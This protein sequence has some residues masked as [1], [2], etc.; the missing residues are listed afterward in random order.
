MENENSQAMHLVQ[1]NIFHFHFHL[2]I[3]SFSHVDC[4]CRTTW[5]MKKKCFA[6]FNSHRHR[7]SLFVFVATWKWR[8]MWWKTTAKNNLQQWKLV[9]MNKSELLRR[10]IKLIAL[11]SSD[12]GYKLLLL[13]L[14]G[15]KATPR[16]IV[17]S[18]STRAASSS[19]WKRKSSVF[20]IFW[21]FFLTKW[22]SR[23]NRNENKR[24]K[25]IIVRDKINYQV[26]LIEAR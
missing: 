14:L 19:K 20:S 13:V 21:Y 12:Y 6:I 4:G 7:H 9:M 25:K 23:E 1:K 8:K 17:V 10:S 18:S 3:S 24:K 26:E 11:T 2:T 22:K 5:I 15:L 16:I